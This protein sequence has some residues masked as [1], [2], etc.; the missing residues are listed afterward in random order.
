MR[1]FTGS[2][3]C[4]YA[5]RGRD[6]CQPLLDKAAEKG[7]G[8]E[9]CLTSYKTRKRMPFE[10]VAWLAA[11]QA[12][13]YLHNR[14]PVVGVALMALKAFP[15]GFPNYYDYA[16]RASATINKFLHTSKF[17]GKRQTLYSLR[18]TF[19]DRLRLAKAHPRGNLPC[20]QLHQEVPSS[21][22]MRRFCG[23][24]SAR[25]SKSINSFPLAM[26]ANGN[27]LTP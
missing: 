13:G 2:S 16:D 14:L 15:E 10:E 3:P 7:L 20:S 17:T 11:P 9:I 12:S 19:K 5:D 8:M 18:H 27:Y 25:R 24:A 26:L 1:C 21:M 23:S 6:A 22:R 4:S